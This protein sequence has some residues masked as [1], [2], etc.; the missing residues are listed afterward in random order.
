MLLHLIMLPLFLHKLFYLVIFFRF[1][2]IFDVELIDVPLV[3][4]EEEIL[5]TFVLLT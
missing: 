2:V 3:V 4:S 1:Q 5:L